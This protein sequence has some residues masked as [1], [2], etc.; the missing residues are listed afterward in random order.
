MT[1][2]QPQGLPPLREI[3]PAFDH[4]EHHM[5]WTRSEIKW[6]KEYATDYASEAL[7]AQAATL[8]SIHQIIQ[9][10]GPDA[11]GEIADLLGYPSVEW[12]DSQAASV[13]PV[14]QW[15]K[16]HKDQATSAWINTDEHDAKW[17]VGNSVGWEI[18]ALYAVAPPPPANV[19][20]AVEPLTRDGIDKLAKV[21]EV[22]S[23]EEVEPETVYAFTRAIEAR[24]APQP[25]AVAASSP[26]AAVDAVD[27]REAFEA[28]ARP[29]WVHPEDFDPRIKA[30]D[31]Y[32]S[33]EVQAAFDAWQ[34]RAALQAARQ[35]QAQQGGGENT[36][37][38]FI[39]WCKAQPEDRV[40]VSID[41]ALNE[42]EAALA[43]KEPK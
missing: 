20:G 13:E 43:T 22:N 36:A 5:K 17:W 11:A 1:T 28:L 2:P 6:I 18:R 37:R 10:A 23:L 41:E 8:E 38:A 31:K 9:C 39:E 40:P 24:F 21:L 34:A 30:R 26:A 4:P 15:Q 16:R 27:E 12:A 25:Q 29:R 42:F 32:N 33:Y 19:P 7:R 14:A 3:E 35:P